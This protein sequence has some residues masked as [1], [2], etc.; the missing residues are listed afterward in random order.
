MKNKSKYIKYIGNIVTIVAII[1]IIRKM[2]SYDIS[3][4]NIFS[5]NR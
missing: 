4:Y 5:V 1:F 3:S 2:L